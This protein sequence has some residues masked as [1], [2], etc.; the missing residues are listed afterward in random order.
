M[1]KYRVKI[2]CE[3]CYGVDKL[4]CFGGNIDFLRD[5]YL[6]EKLFKNKKEAI[7]AGKEKCD[8]SLWRY[9][10]E[11]IVINDLEDK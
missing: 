1:K 6:E 4:G 11:E 9:E 5:E 2:W 10:V 3:H 8:F 7:K